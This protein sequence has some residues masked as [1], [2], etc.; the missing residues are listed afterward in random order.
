MKKENCEDCLSNRKNNYPVRG[1]EAVYGLGV[2]GA[3]VYYFS[4]ATS[5][6]LFV[7]GLFKAILWPAFLVFEALKLLHM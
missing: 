6:W 5:F 2:V 3:V 7:F 1:G 4:T